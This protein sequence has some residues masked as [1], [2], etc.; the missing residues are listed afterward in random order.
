[1]PRS[2]KNCGTTVKRALEAFPGV[3]RAEVSF[4]AG[5]AW[6]WATDRVA[7]RPEAVAEAL[8]DIGFGVQPSSDVVLILTTED[9]GGMALPDSFGSS[10]ESVMCSVP[11]V[12]KAEVIWGEGRARAWTASD[13]DGADGGFVV[14]VGVKLVRALAS[15]GFGARVAPDGVLEVEGMMCQRNCGSTVRQALEGVSGVAR[16]EVSFVEKRARVWAVDGPRLPLS[17]LVDAIESVGFGARVV[18]TGKGGEG[19]VSSPVSGSGTEIGSGLV[20]QQQQEEEGVMEDGDG[21]D[22]VVEVE[23]PKVLAWGEE[24]KGLGERRRAATATAVGVFSVSGMSCAS[25]VGNVEKFVSGL[26]GVEDVRVALL[27]EKVKFHACVFIGNEI[28]LYIYI[29][30]AF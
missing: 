21:G 25:C 15:S 8:E 4:P 16:A 19:S 22:E 23:L 17:V 18:G 11:G 14:D 26:E 3:L 7:S 1:M 10:A 9:N 2:Q 29:F 6:V 13:R 20:Q 28:Y 12:V 24:G 27:A 5:R 30:R